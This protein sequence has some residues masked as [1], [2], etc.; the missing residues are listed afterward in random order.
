MS[1]R[2]VL[3][4]KLFIYLIIFL[5]KSIPIYTVFEQYQKSRTQ[6][7][8]TVAELASRPQNI[9]TLQNAGVLVIILTQI[10][11]VC[12]CTYMVVWVACSSSLRARR[13]MG[14]EKLNLSDLTAL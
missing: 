4:G 11:V 5:I 10:I 6:F 9:E 2:Q 14:M 3:Q 1:Q 8:Q 12:G 13:S 7:V